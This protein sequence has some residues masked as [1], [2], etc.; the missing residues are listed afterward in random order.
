MSIT[1]IK[2]D[3]LKILQTASEGFTVTYDYSEAEEAVQAIV[4][5]DFFVRYDHDLDMGSHK[6]LT[7]TAEVIAKTDADLDRSIDALESVENVSDSSIRD[8]TIESVS[9]EDIDDQNNRYARVSMSCF[10]WDV[11]E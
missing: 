2:S 4:I 6:V 8:L 3:L 9:V 5:D 11:L 1:Q 10:V 7:F